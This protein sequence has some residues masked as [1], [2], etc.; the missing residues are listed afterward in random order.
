MVYFGWLI[1]PDFVYEKR[2]R[3]TEAF[4]IGGGEMHSELFSW[5][6]FTIHFFHL[7]LASI[8]DIFDVSIKI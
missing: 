7:F 4:F 5:Q 2:L 8:Q 3:K 1:L 6:E